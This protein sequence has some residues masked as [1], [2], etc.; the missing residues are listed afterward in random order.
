M[1]LAEGLEDHSVLG[2]AVL[3]KVVV[4]KVVL[5]NSCLSGSFRQGF[6]GSYMVPVLLFRGHA[7]GE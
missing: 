7:D 2:I 3:V 5:A 1:H 6:E 4:V